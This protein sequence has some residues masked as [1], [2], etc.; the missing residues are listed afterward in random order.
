MLVSIFLVFVI[1]IS[2]IYLI[3]KSFKEEQINNYKNIFSYLRFL[4]DLFRTILYIPLIEI[5]MT[6]IVCDRNYFN[7]NIKC[8]KSEH[9]IYVFLSILSFI[10]LIILSCIFTSVSFNKIENFSSNVS[11]YLIINAD[12]FI[13]ISRSFDVILIEICIVTDISNFTIIFFFLSSFISAFCIFIERKYQNSKNNI[14]LN[15]KYIFNL[16]FFVNCFMLFI[17]NLIK[18]KNFRGMFKIFLLLSIVI[19]IYLY[20]FA[21]LKFNIL[22]KPLKRDRDIYNNIRNIIQLVENNYKNRQNLIKLL[23]YSFN[24]SH[25]EQLTKI[26]NLSPLKK[27]VE[28]YNNELDDD[29]RKKLEIYIYQ[30]IEGLFKEAL[31]IFRDSPLLLVNYSIFQLEKMHR[32]HKAYII[33]LKCINLPNL[34]FSEEFFIYRIKRSLEEKGGELGKEQSYISYS[35]QINNMASLISEVSFSYTQL[36]GILLN[37]TKMDINNLKEIAIKIDNLNN[38]IHNRYKLLESFGFINKKVIILYNN[39]LKDI[40][41]DTSKISENL[42]EEQLNEDMKINSYFFNIDSLITKSNFQFLIASGE[43]QNFG[44][45]IKI[46]LEICELLG[47]CDKDVIGQN[48]NIFIPNMLRIPH[49]N[50]LRE[51]AQNVLLLEDDFDKI[52]KLV[53]VYFKTSSKFLIPINLKVGIYYDE[54]NQLIIF[55][56]LVKSNTQYLNKC[57]VMI[58]NSLIIQSFSPN[59]TILLGLE[60][61]IINESIDISNYFIEFY[62]NC[63][64]YF[65]THK[66]KNKDILSTKVKLIKEYFLNNSENEIITW[67]NYKQFKVEWKEIN[68]NNK[69]YGYTIYF[70]S[71]ELNENDRKIFIEE[72]L[73]PRKIKTKHSKKSNSFPIINYNY[74]PEIEQKINFNINS[75]AYTIN[76]NND[77]NN[78][79]TIQQFFEN[80]F[81][82]IERKRTRHVDFQIKEKNDSSFYDSESSEYEEENSDE[83]SSYE[84]EEEEKKENIIIEEEKP[85]EIIIEQSNDNYYEVNLKKVTLKIYDFK[86]HI[87]QDSTDYINQSKMKE[88]LNKEEEISKNKINKKYSKKYIQNNNSKNKLKLSLIHFE[89]EILENDNSTINSIVEKLINKITSPKIINKNILYYLFVYIFQ[90]ISLIIIA[91]ILFDI[92]LRHKEEIYSLFQ[93]NF[94]QCVIIGNIGLIQFYTS[95]YILLKNPHYYNIHQINRTLYSQSIVMILNILYEKCMDEIKYFDCI[96]S[97]FEEKEKIKLMNL[98]GNFTIYYKIDNNTIQ[99][100]LITLSPDNALKEYLFSLYKIINSE[101][102]KLNFLNINLNYIQANTNQLA[103]ILNIKSDIYINC[104]KSLISHVKLISWIIFSIHILICIISFILSLYSRSKIIKEKEKYLGMFF[105]IDNEIIKLMLLK[106]EKYTKIQIDKDN[107]MDNTIFEI[108]Q[109]DNEI[110]SLLDYRENNEENNYF[111]EEFSENMRNIKKK[112]SLMKNMEFKKSM[113]LE[114]SFLIIISIILLILILV[115]NNSYKY[116]AI[117][118]EINHNIILEGKYIFVALNTIRNSI[119]YSTAF[120]KYNNSLKEFIE[121]IPTISLNYTKV[122][123]IELDIHSTSL[124]YNFPGNTSSILN[125]YSSESYCK[126]FTNFSILN[127][128]SCGKFADNISNFGLPTIEAYFF[129]NIIQAANL[130][131]SLLEESINNGNIYYD[132]YYGTPFYVN[133]YDDKEYAIKN[134]FSIINNEGV[135]DCN[136]IMTTLMYPMFQSLVLILNENITKYKINLKNFIIIFIVIYS[137]KIIF[138]YVIFIFPNIIK[139][140]EDLNKT[141]TVLRVIPKIVLNDIIKSEYLNDT[142]SVI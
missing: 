86:T 55:C 30:Y 17:A 70:E 94:N 131:K 103:E 122:K 127:N 49:E 102:S 33:L 125:N 37:N 45:I 25:S 68:I 75:K 93:T 87:I 54:N 20:S 135:K 6:V 5:F 100:S 117:F 115:L 64:N 13:L 107:P 142:E 97:N 3:I 92:L 130:L 8:W 76:E 95:E 29:K 53:P 72:M 109:D 105:K 101:N 11:K 82:N 132:Y 121:L 12:I 126:F 128:I 22:K 58:N 118:C 50:L 38:K 66:I 34:N 2:Y 31:K 39:F 67:K 77:S 52:L 129:K 83:Y 36:Y 111:K 62:K 4:I 21:S 108:I 42:N 19:L 7:D 79:E 16:F 69:T 98:K 24:L 59:A 61:S 112:D 99:S 116:Y 60:S 35:Y 134:P 113:I 74:I 137:C 141:K 88:I 119:L 110:D 104:I 133:I 10:F 120:Y 90:L 1:F 106:C 123:Q 56:Q 63:L 44:R 139:E 136:V 140:N 9:I 124:K 84:E 27:I 114:S 47:Y 81:K 43:S 65:S 40:L 23:S 15:V 32:Y 71:I 78:F 73:S 48:I 85:K 46:S 89:P 80:K 41:H 28:L 138:S 96:D 91:I 51:K 18:Q 14:A 57:I 26:K